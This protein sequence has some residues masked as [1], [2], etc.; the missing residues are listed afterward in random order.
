MD[1]DRDAVERRWEREQALLGLARDTPE[2]DFARGGLAALAVDPTV[3][4]TVLPADP[5]AQPVPGREPGDDDP[6]GDHAAGWCAAPV[7]QDGPRH[8][9][10]LR[11]VH[12]RGR[13]PVAALRRRAV[14]RR[15]GRVPRYP[16][17]PD[18]GSEPG[19]PAARAFPGTVYSPGR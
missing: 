14:A 9:E 6:E 12:D 7:P 15:R 8:V 4:I 17:W 2:K 19:M 3:R 10:R 16:R 1:V 13:R 18:V 5:S 11:G